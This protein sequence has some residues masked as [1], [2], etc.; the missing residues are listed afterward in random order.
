MI[1][2]YSI[3]GGMGGYS[4]TFPDDITLFYQYNGYAS[5]QTGILARI[6]I[7]YA[8]GTTT[9]HELSG[10]RTTVDTMSTILGQT[11][12]HVDTIEIRT[13]FSADTKNLI[14]YKPISENLSKLEVF[15]SKLEDSERL[16]FENG[17]LYQVLGNL[18]MP[19]M[20]FLYTT[21][22]GG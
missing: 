15:G 4:V 20:E 14:I 7:T 19:E 12:D 1:I 21:G 6:I 5:N 10:D 11:I 17:I 18:E 13:P 22:S 2:Q 16:I 9:I 8:D 3:S